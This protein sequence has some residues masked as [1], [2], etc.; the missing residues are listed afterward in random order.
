MNDIA[1][2]FSGVFFG[3]GSLLGASYII[4]RFFVKKALSEDEE[5]GIRGD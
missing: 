2:F 4:N 3:I 5:D 1:I